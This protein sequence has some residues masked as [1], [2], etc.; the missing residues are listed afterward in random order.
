M[1]YKYILPFILL[2]APAIADPI[3]HRGRALTPRGDGHCD[4]TQG[5]QNNPAC[6]SGSCCSTQNWCGYGS[7]WCGPDG[8]GNHDGSCDHTL[9]T[10]NNPACPSGACC[11]TSNWCGYGTPWCG[12]P[13]PID[14]GGD[15]S[16][17]PSKGKTGNPKC[18]PGSC[19]S[20]WGWCGY[21][22]AWCA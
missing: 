1:N 3:P 5:V 13:I 10:N 8:G 22:Q 2:L 15:G 17:D 18:P 14:N 16:C 7:A 11:S 6:P 9:G 4:H 12:G 21:G 20:F 19:C